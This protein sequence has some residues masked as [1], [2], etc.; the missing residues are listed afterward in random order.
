M[1]P[2]VA[3]TAAPEIDWQWQPEQVRQKAESAEDSESSAWLDDFVNHLGQDHQ[4]RHPNEQLT[5]Q[6]PTVQD[7]VLGASLRVGL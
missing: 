3:S 1:R 4:T 2:L 6:L 5:V 7:A